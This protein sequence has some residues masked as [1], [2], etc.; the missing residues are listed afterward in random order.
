MMQYVYSVQ[1]K[2]HSD[3]KEL[4]EAVIELY[5]TN[6]IMFYMEQLTFWARAL[7]ESHGIIVLVHLHIPRN[8]QYF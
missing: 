7:K 3:P 4:Q 1:I 8:Y 6:I 2:L 5:G